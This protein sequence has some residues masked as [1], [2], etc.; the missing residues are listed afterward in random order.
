MTLK[1]FHTPIELGNNQEV[2]LWIL[3]APTGYISKDGPLALG[4]SVGNAH[5]PGR[6][7]WKGVR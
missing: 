5:L 4:T 1:M 3:S 7:Y 2:A 6:D